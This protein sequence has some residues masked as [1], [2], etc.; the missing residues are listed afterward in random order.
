MKQTYLSWVK[1]RKKGCRFHRASLDGV[2]SINNIGL[3]FFAKMRTSM[4][5]QLLWISTFLE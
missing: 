2:I 4:K 3:P 5:M 1:N